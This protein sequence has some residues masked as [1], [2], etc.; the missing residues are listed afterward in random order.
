LGLR[1]WLGRLTA[2]WRHP[3]IRLGQ[4]DSATGHQSNQ[5]DSCRV[6]LTVHE[7]G[8]PLRTCGHAQR[9]GVS[10]QSQCSAQRQYLRGSV[11]Y[12]SAPVNASRRGTPCL[13]Y[14]QQDQRSCPSPGRQP[15]GHAES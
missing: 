8:S 14:A 3:R 7:N 13:Y 9:P 5:D 12:R 11:P 10:Q 4:R 2:A 15:G 1:D 6:Q